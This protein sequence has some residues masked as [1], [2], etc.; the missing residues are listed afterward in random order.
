MRACWHRS[1]PGRR[2]LEPKI[3]GGGVCCRS[4]EER[5]EVSNVRRRQHKPRLCGR[6]RGEHMV[7]MSQ[8]WPRQV[9]LCHHWSRPERR[10]QTRRFGSP[11]KSEKGK[12]AH[13]PSASV[14]F[15][16]AE[17][18]SAGAV[19]LLDTFAGNEL[20][21]KDIE[22][23]CVTLEFSVSAVAG[24]SFTGMLLGVDPVWLPAEVAADGIAAG[25]CFGNRWELGHYRQ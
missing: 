5:L 23:G 6:R 14:S 11:A 12:P 2:P 24:A 9:L 7:M 21:S 4:E 3:I 10:S 25:S 18:Y 1:I 22:G 20:S 15:S 17:S 8:R 16:A 19:Y 13:P